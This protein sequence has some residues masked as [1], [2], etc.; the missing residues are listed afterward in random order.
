MTILV[1]GATGNIGSEVV[2]LL[3]AQG[4]KIRALV[5][6]PGKARKL[7]LP[8]VEL[9]KG[10]LSDRPSLDAAAKGVDAL[11]LLGPAG[12]DQVAQQHNALEAAKAAGIKRVVKLSAVGAQKGSKIQLGDWHGQTEDE[13]KK[14]GLS[15]TI[16]QPHSFLQNLLMSASTI[17]G[18]GEFYGATKE[19]KIPLIDTRDIGAVAAAVLTTAGHEGKTYV[20][21]GPEAVSHTQVAEKL[22]GA[23]GKPVKYVD[24]PPAELKKGLLGAGLPGW[25]AGDLVGMQQFFATG[26]GGKVTTAVKDLT[27]KAARTVDQF[28]RDFAAAFK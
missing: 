22:A 24:L 17:K 21:T 27:G 18:Q 1:T 16:L 5:R 2:K 26:G 3:S 12:P 25:L 20:L 13:L 23:V 11:F 28:A 10:D 4:E 9:V 6:D 19:G 8:G 14:S 15:W 7:E